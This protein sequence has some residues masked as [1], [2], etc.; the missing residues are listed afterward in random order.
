MGSALPLRDLG[1][2]APNTA[3]TRRTRIAL[4]NDHILE[5]VEAPKGVGN[6]R[7]GLGRGW[8]PKTSTGVIY[9]ICEAFKHFIVNIA[10]LLTTCY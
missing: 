8:A 2:G 7:L 9:A 5:I 3:G 4:F 1:T 10:R 6:T